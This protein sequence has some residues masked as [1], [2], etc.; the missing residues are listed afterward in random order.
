[1]TGAGG[2]RTGASATLTRLRFADVGAVLEV[3]LEN[4]CGQGGGYTLPLG[5]DGANDF[6][7]TDDFGGRKAGNFRRQHEADFQL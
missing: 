3:V 6:S 2:P 1:M 4:L 5:S 7:A